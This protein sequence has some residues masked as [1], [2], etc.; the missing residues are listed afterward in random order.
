MQESCTGL[1]VNLKTTVVSEVKVLHC[2]QVWLQTFFVLVSERNPSF[3]DAPY[4]KQTGE[5][6]EP[7][8]YIHLTEK[9]VTDE[10]YT[11]QAFGNVGKYT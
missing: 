10:R 7:G 3:A 4:T 9:F 8:E 11:K 6:G 5:C 2:K 1:L